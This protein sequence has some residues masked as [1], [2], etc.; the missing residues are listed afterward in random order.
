MQTPLLEPPTR[1]AAEPG[2]EPAPD[3]PAR[4]RS[5]GRTGA[6]IL[7]LIGAF[8]LLGQF[9][10]FNGLLMMTLGVILLAWG[11]LI[12]SN[13][14]II[15]GGLLGGLG[16]GLALVTVPSETLAAQQQGAIILLG[17]AAGW[18]AIAAAS[19][20]FTDRPQ[21][22][23][24]IPGAFLLLAG[25]AAYGNTLALNLLQAT[26]MLWPLALIAG[27][28]YLVVRDRTREGPIHQH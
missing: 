2:R 12:H 19:W 9:T 25:L 3:V 10:P 7:I 4:D 24:V 23:A 21:Y 18:F 26:G 11:I 16:A 20:G 13:G 14:L 8:A 15:P 22:W 28:A 1:E 17:F 27:G 5:A 6:I